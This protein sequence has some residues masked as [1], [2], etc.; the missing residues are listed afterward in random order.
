MPAEVKLESERLHY[1]VDVTY[2]QIVGS[3]APH[4]QKLNQRMKQLVTK[5]YQWL[6]HPSQENL[7]RYG[8]DWPEVTNFVDI[9]YDITFA[10]D[11]LLSICFHG[12]SYSIGAAHAVQFSF[13]VNY[14]FAQRKELKLSDIFNPRSKY[15]PFLADYCASRLSSQASGIVTDLNPS[16]ESFKSWNI[17]DKGIRFNFDA[18]TVMGCSAGSQEVEIPFDELREYLNARAP[19]GT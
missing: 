10:T 7:R 16:P 2:P 5:Q 15:L 8:K 9:F 13:V 4:I 17:T 14:D 11:S 6:L 1:Q 18:C 3:K 19:K 12:Y